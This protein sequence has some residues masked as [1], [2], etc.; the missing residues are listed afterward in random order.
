M[1]NQAHIPQEV[2]E[3]IERFLL[4]KMSPEEEEIFRKRLL[5]DPDL[6]KKTEEM[7]LLSI[8]IQESFLEEK[9][10]RFHEELS[11]PVIK[12][13]KSV[14]LL[15]F[16]W[17]A[18]ASVLFA[19]VVTGYLFFVRTDKDAALFAEYYQPDTGLITAMG[20]DSDYQFN[21]GM[22]DY[23]T[24]NYEAAI[25][26]WN[27]LLSTKPGNDTL[28]YFLGSAY[29]ADKK[30]EEAIAAFEKLIAIPNSVFVNDAYWYLGLAQLK[31]G[32]KDTALSFLGKSDHPDKEE[33]LKKLKD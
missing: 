26:T 29:L 18:A 2:L 31:K 27:A 6:T 23:K 3:E 19:I 21:R 5:T 7:K 12:K 30:T 17:L 22:I 9:L 4:Q 1:N 33:L 13:E 25:N 16:K 8:G 10:D 28:N 20:P 14:K 24:G 15:S 11:V 32:N